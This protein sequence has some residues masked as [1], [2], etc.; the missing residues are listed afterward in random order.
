MAPPVHSF[1]TLLRDLSTIV[2]ITIAPA[3]KGAPTWDQDTEPSPVQRRAI[4]PHGSSQIN[5]TQTRS[6]PAPLR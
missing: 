3:L 6:V 2:R 1:Q 5:P 4:Q